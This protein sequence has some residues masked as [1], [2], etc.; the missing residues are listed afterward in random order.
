[1]RTYLDNAA[2]TPVD[3][4]VAQAMQPYLEGTFGNPSSMHCAGRQ[5]RAAV[6][7]A[8]AQVAALLGAESSEIVFTAS[9]TEA[10]NLA[11]LGVFESDASR[12]HIV[13]S[14]IE[15][16]AVLETL[17]LPGVARRLDHVRW[18][19]VP[20]G[21]WRRRGRRRHAARHAAG[22]GDGG[23]QRA[24]HAAAGHGDRP[25]LPGA[26]GPVPHGRRAGGRQGAPGRP[27][28]V[29]RPAVRSRPTSCTGRK[30]SARSS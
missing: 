23:E 15:H 17:R 4:R 9:G 28:L 18:I 6:D 11:L 25:A 21:S 7:V 12:G 20:T 30:G 22:L 2:T 29:D 13:T 19:R 16:P 8:R 5:A 27:G 14:A 3:P 26:P 24:R 1:M 10:D